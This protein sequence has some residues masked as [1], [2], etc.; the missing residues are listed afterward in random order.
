[1]SLIDISCPSCGF[2]R[3]VP[4]DRIPPGA[5]SVTCPQ[6]KT[7]FPLALNPPSS[8]M[9]D[10]TPLRQE[11]VSAPEPP[12]PTPPPLPESLAS[13]EL[14]P[15]RPR[16]E[17]P[18]PRKV[19]PDIGTLFSESW[20]TFQRRFPTLIGLYLL[21]LVAFILPPLLLV[22]ISILA[23]MGREGL[24]MV[25]IVTVGI[26]SGFYLGFRCFSG[27]LHGVVDEQLS[28]KEA[29]ESG[30][31]SVIPLLWVG[32]LTGFVIFGGF[33][34]FIIPGI[35]FMVWFFFAQFITVKEDVRGMGA[36]LKSREYVKGEWF[37][38]ALRL[39]LVWTASVLLGAIPL[40]GPF[41]SIVFMP[42]VMIF[43]YLVYRDL[44]EL[45]GDIPYSCGT[46]DLLKW[47][48][49]ALLG[50]ILVPVAIFTLVGST[51]L[52]K[53]RELA[54]GGVTV[55]AKSDV[56]SGAI[57]N[58]QGYRVINFPPIGQGAA[59]TTGTESST[60]PLQPSVTSQSPT[61]GGEESLSNVHIFIYAV[62]Y[63]GTVRANGTIIKELEGKPDMQYNYNMNGNGLRY[64]QNQIEIDYG[65]LPNPPST[66]LEIHL[67]VSRY[68]PG[69]EKEILGD[70][71]FSEKGTGRKTFTFEIT[72]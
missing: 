26:M 30:K 54:Q 61:T 28:F 68:Q 20:A 40:A 47:P 56:T 10:M 39:L 12:H 1:M 35:I 9:T 65:E 24:L 34:L 38:V 52:V 4:A 62:N 42:Y 57:V 2:S 70:W 41:L 25:A 23:G 6:C 67:K 60:P 71:R 45:K 50:Y 15:P 63:T 66:M 29:L 36:L 72:K 51:A 37:N 17:R 55:T 53:F 64:G 33:L 11:S 32:S 16:R 59:P 13:P 21:T 5:R 69:K 43:H 49:I 22:G 14:P 19:L 27:F 7:A 44:Q 3:Q 8:A 48:G 31:A 58:D 46:G 18:A